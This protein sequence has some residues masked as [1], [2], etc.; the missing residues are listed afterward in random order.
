MRSDGEDHGRSS[1]D[2]FSRKNA[3]CML[4]KDMLQKAPRV[5]TRERAA[6]CPVRAK[7][8]VVC[9]THGYH[10][11]LSWGFLVDGTRP[12]Y[13]FRDVSVQRADAGVMLSLVGN[14]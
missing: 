3:A 14:G 8:T 10:S 1:P 4:A 12:L 2:D 13:T 11:T 7:P 9:P 5:R 6:L